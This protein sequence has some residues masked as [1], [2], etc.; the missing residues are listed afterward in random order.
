MRIPELNFYRASC[1]NSQLS[2]SAAI[3][4]LETIHVERTVKGYQD[5]GLRMPCEADS[6]G[7]ADNTPENNLFE[8]TD[9]P[10]GSTP[11]YGADPRD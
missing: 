4:Q 8:V 2:E 3:P 10:A 6:T 1:R 7:T 11:V 9:D 5:T